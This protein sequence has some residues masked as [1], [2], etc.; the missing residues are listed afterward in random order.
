MSCLLVLPELILE[1]ILDCTAAGYLNGIF[2]V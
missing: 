1:Y 2:I